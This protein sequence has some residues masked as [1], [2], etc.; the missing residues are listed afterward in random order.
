MNHP[1]YWGTS[2]SEQEVRTIYQ[3]WQLLQREMVH[4]FGDEIAIIEQQEKY[5]EWACSLTDKEREEEGVWIEED[6]PPF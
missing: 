4:H 6:N 2:W 5:Y 1:T 3:A